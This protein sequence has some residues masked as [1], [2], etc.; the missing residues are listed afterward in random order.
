MIFRGLMVDGAAACV[1]DNASAYGPSIIDL[2]SYNHSWGD[3][4]PGTADIVGHRL[5]DVP[6]LAACLDEPLRFVI[7]H[8]HRHH[9]GVS[10][11]DCH[12][13]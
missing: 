12:G 9:P 11:M 2:C 8:V 13:L 3:T 4:R 5:D 1:V 6:R 7:P 10:C